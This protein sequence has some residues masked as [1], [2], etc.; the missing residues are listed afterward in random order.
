MAEKR[1]LENV[2]LVESDSRPK[3]SSAGILILRL[4]LKRVAS[5]TR[6]DAAQLRFAEGGKYEPT[7]NAVTLCPVAL[8]AVISERMRIVLV[9]RSR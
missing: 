3:V 2:R 9:A 1:T 7:R 5:R 8:T 4:L 6:R